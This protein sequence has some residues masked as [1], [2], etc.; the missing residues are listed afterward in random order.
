MYLSQLFNS[1]AQAMAMEGNGQLATFK[2][3]Y[4]CPVCRK[5]CEVLVG[6]RYWSVV[7]CIFVHHDE[8]SMVTDVHVRAQYKPTLTPLYPAGSL[9]LQNWQEMP[10]PAAATGAQYWQE[11]PHPAAATG[12][13]YWKTMPHPAAATGA[14]YW[15]MPHPAAATGALQEYCWQYALE[16][17][18]W[19]HA[20]EHG[21]RGETPWS[22]G[23]TAAARALQE[24]SWQ[25]ALEN[26]EWTPW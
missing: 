23:R 4:P 12:A 1:F 13:Q 18:I 17:W 22:I 5:D 15:K 14:Q 19:K 7:L 3:L 24:Y 6:V 9:A 20:V 21:R 16:Y 8:N 10:Q 25:D 2:R 11:M 26:D